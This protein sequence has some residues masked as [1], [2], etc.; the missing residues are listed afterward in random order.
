MGNL[1]GDAYKFRSRQGV[2]DYLTVQIEGKLKVEYGYST[3][4]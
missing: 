3:T 4:T 1:V 2:K